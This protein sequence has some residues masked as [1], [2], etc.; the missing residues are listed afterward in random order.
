MAMSGDIFG[1]QHW[2]GGCYWHLEDRGQGCGYVVLECTAQPPTTKPLIVPGLKTL[3]HAQT[4]TMP[5]PPSGPAQS[6]ALAACRQM[7]AP[8]QLD[9]Q[10]R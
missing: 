2:V 7:T 6:T 1:C 3:L 8:F 10:V 9:T 5:S 4:P